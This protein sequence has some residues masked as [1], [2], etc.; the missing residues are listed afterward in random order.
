M[1]FHTASPE[2]ALKELSSTRYGLTE[3]EAEARYHRH[4]PNEILR[5][6]ELSPMRI[7]LSQFN[8]F[9]VYILIAAVIISLFLGEYLD[10]AVI[11]AILAVNAILGFFQE[12]KA[13]KAIE[14]LR[15]MAT[16][17]ATVIREGRKRRVD[18]AQVVPGDVIVFE[19]GDQISADGRIIEQHLLEVMEAS[20]TGESHP[21]AKT[22]GPI[23]DTSILGNMKNM[24]FGGTHVVNGSG[25][26]V[27]VR[28]GMASEMGRIA[29]SLESVEDDE[30][31]LQKNMDRLGR[32]L[33]VLTLVICG[34][35]IGCGVARGGGIFEMAM[36][37]VSLAVAAVPEGLPIVVT[38][39]LALGVKRMVAQNTL[40]KRLPSVETLGCTTVICTDKTGTLTRNEM[41]VTRLYVNHTIIDVTGAGYVPLGEFLVSDQK[42]DPSPALHLLQIGALN[43]DAAISED[44]GVIGDPTEA[45]LVVSA[46][47]AGLDKE[48]LEKA[49][50]R[51]EEIPFDSE[52][53]RKSTVHR[54]P[55]GLVMLTK[56][57][58]EVI[59]HLSS[60][61]EMNGEVVP[62]GPGD[63]Q[64]INEVAQ[65]F[66][67]EGLRVLAF[68]WKRIENQMPMDSSIET[69]L[70]F[71]GL[72]GMMDP[73]R[74][75]VKTAIQMCK[76]AGI[77]P[78]MITG[79]YALTAEAVAAT[80]GIQG[81]AISGGQIEKMDDEMLAKF[82]SETSIFCR[83]NPAHKI[84]L[85][86]A[87]RN[88]GEVVAMSGDGVNDAPALK[89]ADIGIAMGITGT[90]VT[91]ESADMVLLDDRYTSIVKAVE[92][93][94]A[95]YENIRK[96]VNYLLSSNLA[97]VLVL[98]VAMMIGFQGSSGAM[99]MPLLATQILWLN[100]ITDGLPAI[101]LGLD[102]VRKGVMELPPRKPGEPVITRTMAVNILFISFLM[103]A[104]VLI[105]FHH[106]LPEGE[107][108]ARTVAFTSIVVFEMVR[109]TMVRTRYRLSVFSNLYLVGAI[110]LSL[111]LQAAVVYLPTM[112]RLFKTAPL[113]PYHWL[114]IG[115]ATGVVF[116]LG[117][118]AGRVISSPH[119]GR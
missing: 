60:Q 20:L 3:K 76:A 98:F 97:E 86:R 58:P 96:F 59:L 75:E 33:G 84:R 81:D 70:V 115:I 62:M 42:I 2:D 88:L 53:K 27:V 103:A 10:S 29:A 22:E 74:E 51:T 15:N 77:R 102:P 17:K 117:M 37:G 83:V 105:L 93:G 89:E 55:R 92:Q 114:H 35:I 12:Y 112:N 18:S 26:A 9:I 48:A 71:V 113:A 31:P 39:A 6:K 65:R 79:D 13:E 7:F 46:A 90:D 19:A 44:E 40:V 119:P 85:V 5:Q 87:L 95:I 47:K 99:A 30:T 16:L 106:F 23:E 63:R 1:K 67:S 64:R 104:A 109:V 41:T 91:K 56:G 110:L 45:C 36:V 14:S 61:I 101:A 94:R 82:V 66:A 108:M 57:A 4:G 80:L 34:M 11:A 72:Q 107:T 32:R 118:M 28:T 43:N 49:F 24:V 25:R 52:R 68:A 54:G 78:I 100:L 111:L 116:V 38:T 8:S 21:V 73:P 50:P 69:D